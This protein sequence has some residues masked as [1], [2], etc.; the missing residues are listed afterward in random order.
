MSLHNG[1]DS[2]AFVSGGVYTETYGYRTPG[3]IAS[4]FA[5]YGLQEDALVEAIER[6]LIKLGMTF[7]L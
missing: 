3:A 7:S 5:F 2:V 6:G 1:I 4:L